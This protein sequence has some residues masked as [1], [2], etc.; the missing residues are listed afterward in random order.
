MTRPELSIIVVNWNTKK[1]LGDCLASIVKNRGEVS[2]E[3]I[4]VDN[5]S[6]DGSIELVEKL[7]ESS[8][9]KITL[10]KNANN[11][12]FSKANN[13][14][15]K[16]AKGKYILLLNSD[17]RVKPGCLGRL[18]GYLDNNPEVAAVSPM[19]LN[20]DGSKQ[21]DYYMRFP[22]IWQILLYHNAL[23]RP[24]AIRTPI[25]RLLFS[26]ISSAPFEVDQLP[27]AA[28]VALKKTFQV[29]KG[30]G[31]EYSF[32]FE[33]VD[34]CYRVKSLG[35]GKLVVV[36]EA[37][38]VHIGGA[39]WKKRLGLD[40][41]GFYCQYFD[42]LLLFVSQNYK[43]KRPFLLAMTVV[44]L[45]NALINLLVLKF[46]KSLTQLKMFLWSTRKL[47]RGK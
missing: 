26:K 28:M 27:G 25:K 44:F 15:I 43:R 37:Q 30:L 31:E 23:I 11:L 12:G 41:F 24:L 2:L 14:G 21:L 18:V 38:V 10:I 33:D 29:T 32:L 13:Q 35:L 42:S 47:I 20:L 17:T 19:L 36:P 3:I 34:W 45:F 4:V 22:N 9:T 7:L 40:R 6:T 1:L 8:S 46:A 5:G 16:V 39:S